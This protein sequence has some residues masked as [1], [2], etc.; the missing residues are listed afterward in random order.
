MALILLQTTQSSSRLTTL[1]VVL[2]VL[3]AIAAIASVLSSRRSVGIA[4]D[5]AS[6][7]RKVDE[8][9]VRTNLL[10][11][12]L[13]TKL[14]LTSKRLV[15]TAPNTIMFVFP[16]GRRNVTQPLSR[17]S[18]VAFDTRFDVVRLIIGVALILLALAADAGV[19]GWV[20]LAVL[21]ML[22]LAYSYTAA[23]EVTD[24]SGKTQRIPVSV[25]DRAEIERFVGAVNRQL[26]QGPDSA[27]EETVHADRERPLDDRIDRL[28][29]LAD[30]LKQGLLTEEEFESEKRKLL[31]S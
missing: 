14:V 31:D 10:L 22:A 28:S 13:R 8:S 7:E 19:L 17:V 9:T 29:Q 1:W 20:V 5:L 2:A 12:W 18:N 26:A 4:V 23:I 6:D 3:I 27:P 25:V 16:F 24:S 21:A 30:L 15:G 11:A